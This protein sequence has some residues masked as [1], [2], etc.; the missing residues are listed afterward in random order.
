MHRL[1]KVF[2]GRAYHFSK[3]KIFY[4]FC[5]EKESDDARRKKIL[6]KFR[7]LV[8]LLIHVRVL[9][10]VARFRMEE[11]EKEKLTKGF[12]VISINGKSPLMRFYS[13]SPINSY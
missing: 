10:N 2:A 9:L 4:Y 1:D 11:E 5:K 13:S 8:R 7:R 12:K 3:K 6:D